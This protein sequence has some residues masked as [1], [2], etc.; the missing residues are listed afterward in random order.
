MLFFFSVLRDLPVF[1][2]FYPSSSKAQI[3]DLLLISVVFKVI[4][5]FDRLVSL[6]QFSLAGFIVTFLFYYKIRQAKDLFR[7]SALFYT[8]L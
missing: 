7:R 4:C 3:L 5:F 2:L 6:L 8:F 1:C